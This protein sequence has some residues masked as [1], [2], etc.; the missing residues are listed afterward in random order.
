MP[1]TIAMVCAA[2][3]LTVMRHPAMRLRRTYCLECVQKA[4]GKLKKIRRQ[5]RLE[6]QG[7]VPEATT[8]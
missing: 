3:G 2:C 6:Q 8:P 1:D 5:K 7:P 4:K